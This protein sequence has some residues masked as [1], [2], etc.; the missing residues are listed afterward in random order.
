M[1]RK[2]IV[3]ASMFLTMVATAMLPMEG[4]A[5]NKFDPTYRAVV[6]G[7]GAEGLTRLKAFYSSLQ[8]YLG[9]TNLALADVGCDKCHLLNSGAPEEVLVFYLP[10]RSIVI[11]AFTMAWQ[12]V[13]MASP[14]AAL[15]SLQLDAVSPPPPVCSDYGINCKARAQCEITDFC[16]KPSGGICNWC[17]GMGN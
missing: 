13:Q 16:D 15:F 11:F 1:L 10:R 7:G 14:S 3:S 5:Q 17:P 6:K 2:K 9:V 8:G 12:Q 4:L